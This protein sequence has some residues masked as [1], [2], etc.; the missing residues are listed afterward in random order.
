[1][2]KLKSAE[3]RYPYFEYINRTNLMKIAVTLFWII[4]VALL[5]G[6]FSLNVGQTVN[7]DLL[8]TELEKVNLVAV[9]YV[10]VLAGFLLGLTFWL[11]RLIKGKKEEAR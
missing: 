4:I 8:F 7:I 1:M 10:S 11:V 5:L 3:C 2:P 9:I 6:L